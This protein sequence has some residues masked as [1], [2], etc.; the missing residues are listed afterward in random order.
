MVKRGARHLTYLSRSGCDNDDTATFVTELEESGVTA[1]VI[2]GNVS[3]FED[4]QRAV[5]S[6]DR[7]VKGAVQGALV[8][9]VRRQFR[10]QDSHD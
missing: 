9:K 10:A 3:S 5:R 1:L 4:V 6:S 7:P 2:Q 8:L